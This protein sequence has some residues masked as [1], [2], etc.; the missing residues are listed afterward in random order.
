MKVNLNSDLGESFGAWNMGDDAAM[1]AVVTTANVACGFHAGD[2]NVMQTTVAE[3][4]KNG[5]SIGAH[6]SYPDLQGFGRRPMAMSLREVESLMAYQIGALMG[7]AATCGAKVTHVKP[8]GAINNKAAVDADLAAAIAR[9]I[10]GVSKDLIF[11]APAGSAMIE[12]GR[13]VNLPVAQE[14]FADRNYDD[15]GNLVP[16][17]QP[18]AMVHDNDEAL[19]NV[20]RMVQEKAIV[21]VS[22]KRIP[23]A[24]D[25]VCVHGDS[26]GAVAMARHIRA[27]LEKA[28]VAIVTLPAMLG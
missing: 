24:V 11:L 12:A 1:L 9:G 25:S 14:V 15:D 22:G 17:G 7:V 23:C 27:G 18:N 21:S 6:P 19:N 10:K 8:H 16:R 4:V 20:L 13:K 5:V 28:G 3:A 26:P 2:W